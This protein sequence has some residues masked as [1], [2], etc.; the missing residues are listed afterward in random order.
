[1]ASFV[2]AVVRLA[3]RRSPKGG[4]MNADHAQHVV[5]GAVPGQ[6]EGVPALSTAGAGPGRFAS[7]VLADD[8]Q[9][10][11]FR[12]MLGIQSSPYLGFTISSPLG[13]RPA[14]NIGL[15]ARIIHSE[16]NAKDSFKVFS[17]VIN[18]CYF[19][20]I[21]VASALTA[22]GASGASSGAV[23][24]FGA[25]NTVIAGFLTFLKGSGLPNRL[26]YYGNE[27]KKIREFIEQRERDFMRPG[28]GLNVYDAV[29][30]IEKMYNNLKQD[31]EL[32]TPDS[33]TS[34]TNARRVGQRED[35]KVG[36]IEISK[37]EQDQLS[38]EVRGMNGKLGGLVSGILH[39]AEAV[40]QDIHDHEKQIGDDVNKL[41]EAVTRDVK[42]KQAHFDR[43]TSERKAQAQATL[44]SGKHAARDQVESHTTA[45]SNA[46]SEQRA[47]AV[48][49]VDSQTE[50]LSDAANAQHAR[51][52]QAVDDVSTAASEQHARALQAVENVEKTAQEGIEATTSH[53]TSSMSALVREIS[54]I[55]RT[56]LS[57][58]RAAAAE[59]IRELARRIS[60]GHHDEHEERI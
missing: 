46:A 16:Q 29:E 9:L 44:E 5:G 51:A 14:P 37:L 47:R 59:Q 28:H 39:K 60:Q 38:S 21:I 33:Y 43:E 12:L 57:G 10:T 17:I 25:I 34:V 24:A 56:A 19:L 55:H 36:G 7:R 30:T 32:N 54:D 50:A 26:K 23:T 27:W 41:K 20:Q 15:Y 45:I 48:H 3:L 8:E 53:A 13:T 52:V 31:I 2:E 49:A 11:L 4:V 6:Q 18:A 40:T 35:A 42:G 1:M 22:L 58:G